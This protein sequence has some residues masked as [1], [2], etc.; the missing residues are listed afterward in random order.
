M[1][2]V[3][4]DVFTAEHPPTHPPQPFPLGKAEMRLGEIWEVTPSHQLPSTFTR[5]QSWPAPMCALSR[6]IQGGGGSPRENPGLSGEREGVLGGGATAQAGGSSWGQVSDDQLPGGHPCLAAGS[7]SQAERAGQVEKQIPLPRGSH[8]PGSEK[9]PACRCGGQPSTPAPQPVLCSREPGTSSAGCS[10]DHLFTPSA[11]ALSQAR[12]LLNT[13]GIT[14][15]GSGLASV[16]AFSP[17]LCV[18]HAS[19]WG[20]LLSAA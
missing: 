19:G 10:L 4:R 8:Q 14:P 6:H 13:Q 20:T 2:N 15:F 11:P 16:P 1:R 5:V 17:F 18:P 12:R 7:V 3:G 9:G